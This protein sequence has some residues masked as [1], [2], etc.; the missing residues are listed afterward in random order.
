MIV[1]IVEM[2]ITYLLCKTDCSGNR[3]S[4]VRVNHETHL[5]IDFLECDK[6]ILDSKHHFDKNLGPESFSYSSHSFQVFLNCEQPNLISNH[7]HHHLL[8]D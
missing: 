6:F 8:L 4:V 1:I 7:H 3:V 2:L 5:E